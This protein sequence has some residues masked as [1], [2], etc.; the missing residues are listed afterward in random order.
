MDVDDQQQQ[1]VT[2]RAAWVSRGD[3]HGS[4]HRIH[5]DSR[6]TRVAYLACR[7]AVFCSPLSRLQR[8]PL[9]TLQ[10]R[11][12]SDSLG[13][14]QCERKGM[15][16]ES[17]RRQRIGVVALGGVG[18][19]KELLRRVGSDDE[20]L[21]SVVLLGVTLGAGSRGRRATNGSG[22]GP[23]IEGPSL[24]TLLQTQRVHRRPS[25]KGH[26]RLR[27]QRP[28]ASAEGGWNFGEESLQDTSEVGGTAEAQGRP[29]ET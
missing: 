29:L 28:G 22:F 27:D 12:A 23:G 5:I 11:P 6:H 7:F 24:L 2:R 21:T 10:A 13:V 26:R 16:G 8:S 25:A 1:Q 4:P 20:T 9:S 15:L 17:H 3:S 19:T 18:A 14:V